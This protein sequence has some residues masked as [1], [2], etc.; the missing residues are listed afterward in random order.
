MALL[1][2]L[3]LCAAVPALAEDAFSFRG[4]VHW[5]ASP[6]DVA[7]A[8]GGISDYLYEMGDVFAFGYEGISVS[9]YT[10]YLAY[11]FL[12][13]KLQVIGY[14]IRGGE[15]DIAYLTTA[16]RKVYGEETEADLDYLADT[17][18]NL[19]NQRY[20]ARQFGSARAWEA[21]DGTRIYLAAEENAVSIYYLNPSLSVGYNVVGL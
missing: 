11:A 19:M 17:L 2:A 8:E 14:Q 7:L 4:G 21:G 20:T 3:L 1:T 5:D 6:D 16:L 9:R 13:G 12:Q 15:E 18:T 10:A